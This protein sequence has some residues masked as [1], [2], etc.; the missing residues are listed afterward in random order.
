[1]STA[2][3]LIPAPEQGINN[4]FMANIMTR[5]LGRLRELDVSEAEFAREIN[6]SIQTFHNWKKRGSIPASKIV[7]VAKAAK[8]SAD[9]LLSG[10]TN[11][12]KQ[13]VGADMERVRWNELFDSLTPEQRTKLRELGDT[14]A[15]TTHVGKRSA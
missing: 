11:I 12:N 9:W 2:C 7:K 8:V 13:G 14:I 5:L 3:L 10:D 4:V 15:S 1:M 6:E